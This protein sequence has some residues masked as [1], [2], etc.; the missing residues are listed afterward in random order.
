MRDFPSQVLNV[1]NQGPDLEI[2]IYRPKVGNDS[3]ETRQLIG[4]SLVIKKVGIKNGI[5]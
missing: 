4:L 3:V 2:P 5:G 1:G